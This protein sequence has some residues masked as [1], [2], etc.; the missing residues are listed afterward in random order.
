MHTV[1]GVPTLTILRLE[2]QV[3]VEHLDAVVAAVGD[4][5]VALRVHGQPVRRVEFARA[6]CR[7]G[8]PS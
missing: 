5:D 3:V 7:A 8:R 4:V 6:R 2:V 1:H